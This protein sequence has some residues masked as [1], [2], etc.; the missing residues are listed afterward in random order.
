VQLVNEPTHGTNILDKVFV[1]QSDMYVTNVFKSTVKTKHKA[2][3][4]HTDHILGPKCAERKRPK[5]VLYDLRSHN[6]DRL[7]CVLGLQN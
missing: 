5:V 2:I 7:R 6:V 1:N 3:H 4:L